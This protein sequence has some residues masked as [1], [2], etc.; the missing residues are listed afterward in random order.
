MNELAE[1]VGSLEV[2]LPGPTAPVHLSPNSPVEPPSAPAHV[3]PVLSPVLA[4][5][6]KQPAD[7]AKEIKFAPLTKDGVAAF[8]A[9]MR[10]PST[11]QLSVASSKENVMD[12]QMAATERDG[13]DNSVID[14]Q[15]QEPLGQILPDNQLGDSAIFPPPD[16]LPEKDQVMVEEPQEKVDGLTAPTPIDTPASGVNQTQPGEQSAERPNV[17]ESQKSASDAGTASATPA[18]G[19]AVAPAVVPVVSPTLVPNAPPVDLPGDP[20]PTPENDQAEDKRAKKAQYMRFSRNVR[21]PNCPAPVRK[22]FLEA[23]SDPDPSGK[24]L[25]DLF[26]EFRRCQEDWSRSEI[27]LEESRTSTTA[28]RGIWKWMTRD[29]SCMH[30]KMLYHVISCMQTSARTTQ[31]FPNP[32]LYKELVAKYLKEEAVN[33]LIQEKASMSYHTGMVAFKTIHTP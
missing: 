3:S 16:S 10:R 6:P 33:K 12:S 24:K 18:V 28:N 9:A 5:Q 29:E 7:P 31:S 15:S 11:G 32:L 8:F 21:G 19:P 25:Q 14:V 1:Q 20:A 17:L 22:K 23:M 2:P 4:T 26:Q 30:I 13:S 27:V